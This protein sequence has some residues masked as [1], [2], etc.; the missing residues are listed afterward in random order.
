MTLYLPLDVESEFPQSPSFL[1][2]SPDPEGQLSKAIKAIMKAKRIVVVCG[3]Y[4]VVR[5]RSLVINL[6]GIF[7]V[8]EF[9]CKLGFLTLGP[10]RAYSKLL[11]GIILGSP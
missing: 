2:S 3:V 6:V 1:V 10:R 8:Q 4:C 11:S 7:Q 5:Q 9:L